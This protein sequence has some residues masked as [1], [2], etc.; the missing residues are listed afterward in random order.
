MIS[1]GCTDRYCV[2]TDTYLEFHE[3]FCAISF[4]LIKIKN[5]KNNNSTKIGAWVGAER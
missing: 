5:N 3:I 2:I 4:D 1:D